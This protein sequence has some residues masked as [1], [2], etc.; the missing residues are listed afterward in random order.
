MRHEIVDERGVGSQ[1]PG[2]HPDLQIDLFVSERRGVEHGGQARLPFDLDDEHR[3]T[4]AP[5]RDGEGGGDGGLADASL[6]GDDDDAGGRA[7]FGHLHCS[8]VRGA[9]YD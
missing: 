4:G 7:E 8:I 9:C 6:A 2:P 3:P 1:E 5:G